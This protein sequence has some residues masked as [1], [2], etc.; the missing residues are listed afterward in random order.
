MEA[1]GPGQARLDSSKFCAG[2]DIISK[3]EEAPKENVA[4]IIGDHCHEDL[5]PEALDYKPEAEEGSLVDEENVSSDVDAGVSETNRNDALGEDC[6]LKEEVAKEGRTE[7]GNNCV[8]K[9]KL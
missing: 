9:N 8:L 6:K 7:R 4:G 3:Q 5:D 1:S 2:V